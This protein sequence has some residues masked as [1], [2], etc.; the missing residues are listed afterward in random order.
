[1]IEREERYHSKLLN[2]LR[3]IEFIMKKFK[4]R[5]NSLNPTYKVHCKK[6]LTK[7]G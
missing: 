4:A 2:L 5:S 1:M 7:N 6:Y 3:M